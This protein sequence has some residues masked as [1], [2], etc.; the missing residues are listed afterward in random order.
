MCRTTARKSKKY[1]EAPALAGP[2]A[3]APQTPYAEPNQALEEL[4]NAEPPAVMWSQS[5]DAVFAEA[6]G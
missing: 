3:P 1:A 5:R 6:E 4:W 2:V